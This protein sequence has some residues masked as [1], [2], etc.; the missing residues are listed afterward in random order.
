MKNK[1]RFSIITVSYNVEKTIEQ[2]IQSVISQT[3]D[4]VEYIIID[5]MSTDNTVDI[6]RKYESSIFF[7]VSE[8]DDGI[9]DAMNKGI[10]VAT[11]DYIYF[12]GADDCLFQK[13]TIQNVAD[14]LNDDI[15]VLSAGVYLVDEGLKV[16]R[17]MDGSFAEEKNRFNGLMIPH[18]GMFVR[19][20]L[21]GQKKFDLRYKIASDYDLFLRLYLNPTIRFSFQQMVIAYYSSGGISTCSYESN[22]EYIDIMVKHHLDDKII[23]YV[24]SRF[25]SPWKQ[26]IKSLLRRIGLMKFFLKRL[27]AREHACEWGLCRWCGYKEA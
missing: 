25:N 3:Y 7:W 4:N 11:G 19:R 15:D 12:L 21:F 22:K 13:N 1:Y 8:K 20:C 6:I 18:Q 23:S 2:A 16:E 9:Y 17:Y 24:R 27:G 14:R 26:S 10:D 5:G